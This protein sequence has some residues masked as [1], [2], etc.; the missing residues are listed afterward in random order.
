M[1]NLDLPYDFNKSIAVDGDGTL[2][3]A[4]Y[5]NPPEKP[6]EKTVK[7]LR[8]LHKRG[9]WI[10]IHSCRLTE[11]NDPALQ[12]KAIMVFLTENKIPYNVIWCSPGK[13]VC[14]FYLDDSAYR[15]EEI[16]KLRGIITHGK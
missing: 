15:P 4:C 6:I 5:P 2:W 9:W 13:P 10:V 11:P 12:Y 3:E 8:E 7:L 14:R 1:N 16:D